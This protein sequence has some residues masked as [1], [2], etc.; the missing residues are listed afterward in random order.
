MPEVDRE[1]SIR[2]SSRIRPPGELTRTSSRRKLCLRESRSE[3]GGRDNRRRVPRQR[4]CARGPPTRSPRRRSRPETEETLRPRPPT[5]RGA[6]ATATANGAVPTGRGPIRRH[7]THRPI[8]R[9]RI[10]SPER[11][12][13]DRRGPTGTSREQG[14][15]KILDP[16]AFA[17]V[18]QPPEVVRR[19]SL[20]TGK[21][22][23]IPAFGKI[24]DPIRHGIRPPAGAAGE[25][26]GTG[27]ERPLAPGADQ[28]SMRGGR[29]RHGWR[30]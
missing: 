13:C 20:G 6:P 17:L 25:L 14:Q 10:R 11:A 19:E 5:G 4:R 24:G 23:V 28:V 30:V 9:F 18:F 27:R 29:G 21:P 2:K 7:S 1:V 12:V 15:V 22:I 26:L 3:S 16:G 8:R